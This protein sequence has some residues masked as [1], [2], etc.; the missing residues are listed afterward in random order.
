MTFGQDFN[1]MLEDDEGGVGQWVVIRHFS[2]VHS[3]FWNEETKEAI[4]GPPFE[5]TDTVVLAGKQTAFS[6]ARPDSRTGLTRLEHAKTIL[7]DFRYFLRADV[8]IKEDDEIF[9]LEYLGRDKPTVDYDGSGGGAKIT[10]KFKVKFLHSF[11]Q[12]NRG[13]VGYK[14][15][16]TDRSFVT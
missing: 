3:R 6:P 1:E 16:I 7:T 10:A 13:E 4:G 8:T 11:V 14:L 5:F 15:V 9:D 12:G 2:D